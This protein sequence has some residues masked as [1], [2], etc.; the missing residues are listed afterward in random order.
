VPP[1]GVLYYKYK[2]PEAKEEVT[3]TIANKK[4]IETDD[5]TKVKIRFSDMPMSKASINGLFKAKF[6]KLTDV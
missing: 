4:I 3:N 2:N 5:K 1:S 6:V